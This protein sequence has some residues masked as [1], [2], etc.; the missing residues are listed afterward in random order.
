MSTRWRSPARQRFTGIGLTKCVHFSHWTETAKKHKCHTLLG[1]PE[2]THRKLNGSRV[3][4]R[5]R[6]HHVLVAKDNHPQV[7]SS[8]YPHVKTGKDDAK[9]AQR[10]ETRMTQLHAD[11]PSDP[12]ALSAH[13]GPW[14]HQA[15][16]RSGGHASHRWGPAQGV[17]LP[18]VET[19]TRP[20]TWASR[21]E[22]WRKQPTR[23][24]RAGT[25]SHGVGI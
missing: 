2:A 6:R 12:Q 19:G 4:C 8:S 24:P 14:Q 10:K 7:H 20:P 1:P 15:L 5:G 9:T 25:A 16:P 13:T 17:R 11:V 23:T 22:R 21:C 3:V 18:D